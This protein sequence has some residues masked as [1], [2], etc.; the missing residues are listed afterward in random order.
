MSFFALCISLLA[1]VKG[2]YHISI[3]KA[4]YTLLL[5]LGLFVA[6]PAGVLASEADGRFDPI[7]H[8]TQ[9][10]HDPSCTTPTPGLINFR[11]TGLPEITI[12]DLSGIDG[13]AWGSEIGW[14]NFDPSGPEEVVV[15][16]PTG[17]V[18]GKAWAQGS[19]WV[20]FS[21]TGQTVSINDRGEFSGY[22]WT[23]GPNGGWIKF[24]CGSVNTCV[25]TD[26]RPLPYRGT[27]GLGGGGGGGGGSDQDQCSNIDGDQEVVPS[28]L[29][30]S[31]N[32]CVALNDECPNL[33]GVQA[34]L[35]TPFIKDA[36]GICILKD[37]DYC[38]NIDGAQTG[39]P[40]GKTVLSD[41]TCVDSLNVPDLPA[42]VERDFCPNLY[43]IQFELPEGYVIDEL[44]S[45][46]PEETDYCPNVDGAQTVVP[47]GE[48]IDNYGNCVVIPPA[49]VNVPGEDDGIRVVS[50]PFVPKPLLIPLDIIFIG[51]F[52]VD[53]YGRPYVDGISIALT[54]LGA[55]VLAGII[56]WWLLLLLAGGRKWGIVYNALSKKAIPEA[57]VELY[58]G[59]GALVSA[60]K[61]NKEGKYRFPIKKGIYK[62]KVIA[63]QYVFPS[64]LLHGNYA[65][66][67]GK[68]KLDH[69]YFGE[70]FEITSHKKITKNIPVDP[71]V[72]A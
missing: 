5:G 35:P 24:D 54:A 20:N 34:V 42:V 67:L 36:G 25:K 15:D 12:E 4:L 38:S 47:R 46:V 71:S 29:T 56:W 60:I 63:P 33:V 51:S 39:V 18:S 23:G 48:M 17:I 22:A 2:W 49:T 6:T 31:G 8:T 45:C 70:L 58:N 57:T 68:D 41:G 53:E 69:L 19:G 26:W 1:I 52:F 16:V 21:V 10:C 32:Q 3:M 7:F 55:I 72:S 9:V 28:G 64:N 40:L 50:Y 27:G 44:G 59:A 13:T 43:D 37:V 62:I 14:I 61:T 11:V 66:T 65:D 30:K